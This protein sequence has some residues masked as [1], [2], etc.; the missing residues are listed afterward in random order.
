VLRDSDGNVLKVVFARNDMINLYEQLPEVVGIDSRWP[1]Y[2]FV[3]T[4]GFGRGRTV[5]FALMQTEKR[6]D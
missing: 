2:Q 4:D 6:T 3:I 5:L 1:L